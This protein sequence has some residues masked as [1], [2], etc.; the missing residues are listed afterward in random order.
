[1]TVRLEQLVQVVSK[2]AA[3]I[4]TLTAKVD[5]LIKPQQ[6]KLLMVQSNTVLKEWF[7]T[8]GIDGRKAFAPGMLRSGLIEMRA[9]FRKRSYSIQP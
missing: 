1:M 2:Q 8:A 3:A 7:V 4:A 6:S 9:C 5:E